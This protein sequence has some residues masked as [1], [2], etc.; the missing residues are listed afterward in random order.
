MAYKKKITCKLFLVAIIIITCFIQSIL[1]NYIYF[2][3]TSAVY[4]HIWHQQNDYIPSKLKFINIP[5]TGGTSIEN[6]ALKQLNIS[7]GKYAMRHTDHHKNINTRN[8]TCKNNGCPL[9]HIPPKWFD[10][11]DYYNITK[12]EYFCVVRNPFNRIISEYYHQHRNKKTNCSSTQRLNTF[13][14]GAHV[15]CRPLGL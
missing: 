11:F 1:I 14:L 12:Y 6:S 7:W 2:Y 15:A 3:V 13:Y 4:E 5:K 9:W 10:N 8:K